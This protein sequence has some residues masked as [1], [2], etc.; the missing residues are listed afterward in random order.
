MFVMVTNPMLFNN[1]MSLTKMYLDIYF[2]FG[3][4]ENDT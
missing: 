4:F 3:E 1:L 2:M